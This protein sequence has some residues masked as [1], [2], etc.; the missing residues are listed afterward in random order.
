MP[1]H[2]TR[3]QSN[4]DI[5]ALQRGHRLRQ[6]AQHDRSVR[7]TFCRRVTYA[8]R[9]LQ[10]QCFLALDVPLIATREGPHGWMVTLEHK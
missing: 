10:K 3:T 1:T 7:D 9:S 8:S 6:L 5:Q 4:E 2:G